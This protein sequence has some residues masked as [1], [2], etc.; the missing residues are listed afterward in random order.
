MKDIYLQDLQVRLKNRVSMDYL[1]TYLS[2]CGQVTS[3]VMACGKFVM[4]FVDFA[5]KVV[6]SY[7][8]NLRDALISCSHGYWCRCRGD[9]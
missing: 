6:Y 7:G 3:T 2:R 5:G 8:K 4:K 9:C 1:L